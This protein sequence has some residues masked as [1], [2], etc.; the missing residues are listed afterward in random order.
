MELHDFA[1]DIFP[2]SEDEA[3]AGIPKRPPKNQ[4]FMTEF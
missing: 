2:D 4:E 3:E 1:E